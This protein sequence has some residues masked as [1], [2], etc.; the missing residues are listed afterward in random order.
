[1]LYGDLLDAV[2]GPL[3][4]IAANLPYLPFAEAD[5]HPDLDGEPL[6][7]IFAP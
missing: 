3:D 6:E 4:L 2:P 7:A 5:S 1:V